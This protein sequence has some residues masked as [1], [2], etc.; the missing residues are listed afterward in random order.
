M[1][2]IEIGLIDTSFAHHPVSTV[3]GNESKH[4]FWNREHP[5]DCQFTCFTNEQILS[6]QVDLVSSDRRIALLYESRDTMAWLYEACEINIPRFKYFFTHEKRFLTNFT[7]TFWIPGNGIWIGNNYGGGEIGIAPK[8]RLMSF[9]TSDKQTTAAQRFRYHLAKL[10]EKDSRYDIDVYLRPS[11][12]F[13]Y[14]PIADCLQRYCFSII[15]ENTLSP[16]YFTEK[17]LNCFA[18]G[19]VPIYCGANEIDSF[20]C[21][22]GIIRFSGK[23]QLLEEIMPTLN[24]EYYLSKM[25]AIRHNFSKSLEYSSIEKVIAKTIS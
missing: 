1:K 11:Y 20:F 24:Y 17:I 4:I 10:L 6:S 2:L 21:D 14:I 9:I 22:E 18:L 16:K 8:D 13:A 25:E 12:A 7:N 23:R 3:P 19:T 5:L 15:I